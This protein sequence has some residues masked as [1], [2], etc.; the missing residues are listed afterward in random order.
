MYVLGNQMSSLYLLV[1]LEN[2]EIITYT[3]RNI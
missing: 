1:G 2:L 3:F